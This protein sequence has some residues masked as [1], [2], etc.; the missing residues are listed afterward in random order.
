V[1]GTDPVAAA[2]ALE[3]ETTDA[4]RDA[5]VATGPVD[6]ANESFAIAT[7]PTTGYCVPEDGGCSY[8]PGNVELDQGEP[9]REVVIDGAYVAAATPIIRDRIKR[10]GVRLAHL[11]DQALA[12]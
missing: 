10:A 3:A 6:W 9:K 8:A 7:A 5:W 12:D 4:D 2:F 1:V 11:L